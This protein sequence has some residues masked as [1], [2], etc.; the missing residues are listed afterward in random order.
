MNYRAGI[1]IGSTTVK[2]VILGENG[3]MIYKRYERHFSKVKEKTAELLE[4]AKDI[5]TGNGIKLTMTGSAGQGV[6][7][8]CGFEF[9]QEVF[10]TGEMVKQ[11]YPETDCV[12]ELGGE[13]AKIIFLKNGLEE[14]MNGSCAGG[15]GSFI[16]QMALLLDVSCRELDE[17]SQKAEKIHPIAS[18][19]GVFAKSDIQPLLNQ[20]AKKENIAA[21]I[22]QA[23]VDQTITGLAQGREIS[24]NVLF[25]GGPLH[26]FSGLQKRFKETLRL[27]DSCAT[28]PDDA[29]YAVAL[30][31]ALSAGKND[32]S[33]DFE[34]I[35]EQL[36]KFSAASKNMHNTEALFEN[37]EQYIKF[38]KRHSANSVKQADIGAYEGGAYLGIDC[39][40]TTTKIVL[41]DEGC[42]ILYSFYA[43]NSGNPVGIISEELKKIRKLCGSKITIKAAAV[44]GY[45]EE[46]VKNAFSADYGTVE[47]IAHFKAAKYFDPNV[48]FILDIG[49][50][51]IKCFKI[52]NGAIDNIM[53]NEACSS[54]CGSF[55]ENFAKSMGYGVE[56]F[57]REGIYAQNPV[58]LGSRCTVFMNSSVKQ[59]QKEGASIGDISAGL[60]M[61]VV[62]NALYKVIRINDASEL[63][64]N[65]VVQGGTFLNDAILAAFEKKIGKNVTRP[66]IS[67][68]MGAFGCAIYAKEKAKKDQ[69]E[70]SS[71]LPTEELEKF[72]HS[73]NSANCNLCANKCA[74][75]IN[76]FSN[77]KKYISGNRCERALNTKENE[78]MPEMYGFKLDYIKSVI[79]SEKK[80]SGKKT[81]GM[82]LGLNFY[83]MLPFWYTLW[84]NLGFNAEI[85][86]IST[87]EL[88]RLGQ[89][90]I[91]SDTICYPAKL[92]HGHIENLIEKNITHIFYPC[93]TY[94]FDEKIS[95]NNY[96]CPVVAYYPEVLKANMNSLQNINFMMPYLDVSN[97]KLF[98]KKFTQYYNS[99]EMFEPKSKKIIKNA[100]QK[101]YKSQQ[102]YFE[103]MLAEGKRAV[104]AA[105]EK[106]QKLIVLCGR[107]Y[108]ADPEIN[109][110]INKMTASLDC[111]TISEDAAS[112][113]LKTKPKTNVLNQ[114][115]YHA[116]LYSAAEFA[117]KRENT[118]LVQLVSF[119]CGIDAVTSDEVRAILEKNSKLYTQI[120]IDEINNLGAAKIRMRSMLEVSGENQ[121][122]KGI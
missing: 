96:N 81:I 89:N 62:K 54:G 115:T 88:Y 107:P 97:K 51:D 73:S 116:R 121:N 53:L 120:K 56:D 91:P 2:I 61:S 76:S 119:G 101:A 105:A 35:T 22:F 45:G 87:R 34:N 122:Q 6:A 70:K 67:G 74:I 114:W 55:I 15:T 32:I 41:T 106:N 46:L 111:V 85:S 14:R 68:L 42:N 50:Q 38:K 39:G 58:D 77:K 92:M 66:N 83:E 102:L 65:I 47:T 78:K 108:H 117:S 75:T 10:V 21:S 99:L 57:C 12:I 72:S 31:A 36:E 19:C 28:F 104:Q 94:N 48:T 23:V 37:E 93:M 100:V 59:A 82:P 80:D 4:D 84:T 79:N 3:E 63:G 64:E 44:T 103:V 110:G 5:L 113:M 8:I 24:G 86:D 118:E 52:K 9:V 27:S 18:R 90:S 17:L 40:S 11:Y 26:F 25:L 49:G 7:Q 112:A 109:H 30:G 16:D 60:S 71:V 1:D 43:A 33:H 20:G 98:T 95:D 13:D 69:L 29:L